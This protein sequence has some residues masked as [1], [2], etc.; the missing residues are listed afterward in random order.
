LIETDHP[1]RDNSDKLNRI[2]YRISEWSEMTG[3]SRITTWRAIRDGKLKVVDYCGIKLIP[4]S[5][6]ARLFEPGVE[7]SAYARA[8]VDHNLPNPVTAASFFNPLPPHSYDLVV[9]DPP[10]PFETRSEKG[11]GKSP[12]RHYRTMTLAEIMALPVRELLKDDAVVFLWAQGRSLDQAFATLAAWGITYKTEH[13]WRKVTRNGLVRW[14]TGFLARS[15][16][17]PILR[18]AVGKPRCFA[19][20]SCFDGI[21]REHSRKPDEFYRMIVEK[22]PGLRRA[23]LFARERREGWDV[24]G[25]EVDRFSALG[26]ERRA[27]EQAVDEGECDV[28]EHEARLIAGLYTDV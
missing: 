28:R 24:W 18:G 10:V 1:A 8:P 11:Q 16:H 20:P 23:D 13:V 17:E 15:M 19:L 25:D 2:G 14:G 5:E 12:S 9:I 27:R 3:T 22:T 21:A 4:D 6:R 26:A 7:R